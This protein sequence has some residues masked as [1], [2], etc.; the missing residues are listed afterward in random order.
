MTGSPLWRPDRAR[1]EATHLARFLHHLGQP[2]YGQPAYGQSYGQGGQPADAYGAPGQAA[3]PTEMP[4]SVATAVKLLWASIALSVLST[5]LTFVLLDSIVDKALDD[6]GVSGDVDTDLVRASAIAGGLFGLVIGVGITLLLLTFIKKGAN[7]ARIV[8]TVLGVIGIL[9]SL[10]SLG[11]Q[12]AVLLL[13]AL[14]GLAL[15]IA[16]LVLLY[17]PESN[18]YFRKA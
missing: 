10:L 17:R 6:A 5:L 18:A 11:G 14:V 1:A 3:R 2:D 13:L 7:W 12:P 8:Y 9:F 16:V 15:T 4:A